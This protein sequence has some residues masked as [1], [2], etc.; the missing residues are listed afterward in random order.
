MHID[1]EDID[2][3]KSQH[4]EDIQDFIEAKAKA[5]HEIPDFVTKP[6]RHR[7][8]GNNPIEMVAFADDVSSDELFA[9]AKLVERMGEAKQAVEHT[10]FAAKQHGITL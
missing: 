9:F 1:Q 7:F 5:D 2:A 8:V 4:A 3:I 10:E 6:F